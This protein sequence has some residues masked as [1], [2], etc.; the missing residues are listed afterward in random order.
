MSCEPFIEVERSRS[1]ATL[2]PY[3]RSIITDDSK[4]IKHPAVVFDIDATLLFN[5]QNNQCEG[6]QHCPMVAL[7]NLCL[8][9]NIAIFLITARTIG[10][11][12]FTEK[13]LE[14]LK[15]RNY[16]RLFLRPPS[17]RSW[18]DIAAYKSHARDIIRNHGY[19]ILLNAGDQWS[20]L[21]A[22][23]QSCLD[24]LE[25]TK[26]SPFMLVSPIVEDVRWCLKLASE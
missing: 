11:R 14:C 3:L 17:Y 13:Q 20:D 8:K 25:R 23:T 1:L 24:S 7:Y 9:N 18:E 22:S 19:N 26:T 4:N 6:V 2:R 12:S 10:G 16:K 21:I 15:L 5:T